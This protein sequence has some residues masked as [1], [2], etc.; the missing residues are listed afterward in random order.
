MF[1]LNNFY[2]YHFSFSPCI[3][4]FKIP[5]SIKSNDLDEKAIKQYFNYQKSKNFKQYHD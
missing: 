5:F 1:N 2:E 3:Q 4:F